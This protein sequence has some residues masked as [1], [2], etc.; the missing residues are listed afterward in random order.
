MSIVLALVAV[1]QIQNHPRISKNFTTYI[2]VLSIQSLPSNMGSSRIKTYV[3][4]VN[5]TNIHTVGH[6]HL[7]ITSGESSCASCKYTKGA[8]L[9]DT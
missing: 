4:P 9:H 7:T 8:N 5:E 3:A 6:L 1:L 2:S